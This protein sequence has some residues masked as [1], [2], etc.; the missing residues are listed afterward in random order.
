MNPN[1]RQLT[2]RTWNGRGVGNAKRRIEREEKPAANEGEKT[3]ADA[4]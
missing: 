3:D 2:L 1:Q 4:Q